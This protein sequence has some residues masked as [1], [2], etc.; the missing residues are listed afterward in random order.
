MK[1]KAPSSG[2]S[3]A[4]GAR[5]YHPSFWQVNPGN[6]VGLTSHDHALALKKWERV[7]E[8]QNKRLAGRKILPVIVTA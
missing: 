2:K 8:Q 6:S 4:V 3:S 1:H 5:C 7:W